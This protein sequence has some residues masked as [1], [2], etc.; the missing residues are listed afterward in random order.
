MQLMV[1]KII[2]QLRKMSMA[3][4]GSA[5]LSTSTIMAEVAAKNLLN[6]LKGK[7][8]IYAANLDSL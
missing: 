6:V 8:P 4:M 1:F 2:I 3:S 5:T 7:S